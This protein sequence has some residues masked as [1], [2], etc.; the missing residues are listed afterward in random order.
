MSEY[1]SAQAVAKR[2]GVPR[3][4]FAALCDA[5]LG[6][7][8]FGTPRKYIEEDIS[9]FDFREVARK[10]PQIVLGHKGH[11]NIVGFYQEMFGQNFVRTTGEV[12]P[13]L[14][15]ASV[16]RKN[17]FVYFLGGGQLVKIGKADDPIARMK[18]HQCGSPVRLSI[19]GLL[20]GPIEAERALHKRFHEQRQYGEWFLP[21]GGLAEFIERWFGLTDVQSTGAV[22][23]HKDYEERIARLTVE[24]NQAV[25]RAEMLGRR[26]ASI[27]KTAKVLAG[28]LLDLQAIETE[29]GWV[30]PTTEGAVLVDHMEAS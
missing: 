14:G 1:L 19:L 22:G 30:A 29:V 8:S 20:Y 16:Y 12:L 26:I 10:N 2:L 5:G 21:T 6:P 23:A 4:V 27:R 24:K 9:T 11:C 25:R 18:G 7:R 15:A 13:E 28:G 17:A 3:S